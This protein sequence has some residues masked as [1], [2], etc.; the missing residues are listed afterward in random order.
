MLNSPGERSSS[1][2]SSGSGSCGATSTKPLPD[3]IE[4][5]APKIEACRMAC[6]TA[7]AFAAFLP[8]LVSAVL[9]ALRAKRAH[10]RRP[11][12]QPP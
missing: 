9:Y 12:T 3:P 2:I 10:G 4:S 6:G 8:L 5:S 1:C 7:R 11:S